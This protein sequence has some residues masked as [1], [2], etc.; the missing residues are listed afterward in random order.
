MTWAKPKNSRTQ[1]NNAGVVLR[2]GNHSQQTLE[3]AL[4]F[5]IVSNWR[6]SHGL[7]MN[8]FQ[9]TLRS[10]LLKIKAQAIVAQRLKRMPSIIDKLKRERQMQL[11]R[12]QDVGGL[13][14]VVKTLYQAKTLHNEY[15]NSRFTHELVSFRDYINYPKKSGYRS[16][17]LV[18]RY[19]NYREPN[20][21]GLLIELQI[22]TKNQH[23]WATAVET[24]GTFLKHALKSSEGP[25]EWLEFFAL[26]GSGFAHL[27]KTPQ[28]PGFESLTRNDTYK[29]I[30]NRANLL[31]VKDHLQA[32]TVAAKNIRTDNKK[33]GYHLIV[34]DPQQKKVLVSSY[35]QKRL[36]KANDA[37]S[38]VERRITS[39]EQLVAVLVSAGPIKEL[40]R[41]Y[42]NFFLDTR[43]F[44]SYLEIIEK[45]IQ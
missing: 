28:V 31:R 26:T 20:Y 2:K 33:G 39:G 17:H 1:I 13:R 11:F 45:K 9:A 35:S 7:P 36:N 42:P 15:L 10:K 30:V 43:E 32:F 24:M 16:I 21:D 18:Y 25:K 29:E 5:E 44:I 27:E 6:S 23:A 37:Y 3:Y 8:T 38:E 12:M 14:A 22:R 40:K 41:A 34:L 19:K 4:A